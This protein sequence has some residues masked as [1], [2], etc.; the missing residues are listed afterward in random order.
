MSKQ[1]RYNVS[2]DTDLCRKIDA[3]AHALH[4]SRS[5]AISVMCSQALENW[6]NMATLGEFIAMCKDGKLP[7]AG[8]VD[9]T[10][11]PQVGE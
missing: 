3:Y 11:S 6:D 1:Q 9:H 5:A 8:A 10:P 7:V 2:L 4:I